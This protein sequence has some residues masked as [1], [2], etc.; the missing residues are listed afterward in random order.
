MA[1]REKPLHLAEAEA[2]M[3]R[4]RALFIM[5]GIEDPYLMASLARLE[6][7]G[8]MDVDQT[9]TFWKCCSSSCAML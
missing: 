4:E 1:R 2:L 3:W 8:D 5:E 7:L 9:Q 6:W